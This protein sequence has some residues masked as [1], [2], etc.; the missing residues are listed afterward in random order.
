MASSTSTSPLSRKYGVRT[1]S[2]CIEMFTPEVDDRPVYLA[3]NFN[4]W[5]TDD[6]RFKMENAGN[7]YYYFAFPAEMSLPLPI[8]YKYLKEG[9]WSEVELD[10]A[11]QLTSNRKC[12]KSK[13]W[14]KD[15]VK[16]W[17]HKFKSYKSKFR[18][19]IEI[20]SEHFE[21]PQLD[22]TRRVSVLLPH[23]YHKS[24]KSYPV[25]YLQ[26]GQNLFDDQAPF[27]NWSVDKKMSMLAER[28]MGDLIVVAIDHGGKERIK[29][30]SPY[31][32]FNFEGGDGALYVEFIC[33]TLKPVIDKTYR[34]LA[35]QINTGIGGSSMGG[36]ISIYA[37]LLRP[38]IFSKWLIFSPSLWIAPRIKQELQEKLRHDLPIRIYLYA[39]GK[40]S[41]SML[42]EMRT[43]KKALDLQHH[44]HPNITSILETDS[45]GKHNE[46]KWG[47]EFPKAVEWLY[48]GK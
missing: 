48:F 32:S 26:D 33:D 14:R 22:R 12:R 15:I 13:G 4:E 41:Q 36:L 34:T 29:E 19:I 16:H 42:P 38:N 37:A 47:L 9:G 6:E 7:G 45:K 44:F 24:Q 21:I 11:G 8:E 18:P 27:G 2:L 39:G 20:I 46:H 23:D 5:K 30:F 1:N 31:Q 35:D 28:G 43:L 10:D 40:E 3:G 25:L 17:R